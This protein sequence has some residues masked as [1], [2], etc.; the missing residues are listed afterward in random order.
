MRTT[1]RQRLEVLNRVLR[2]NLRNSMNVVRGHA[3]RL[4]DRIGEEDLRRSV[5]MILQ[6]SRELLRL[7]ERGSEV[8][9]VLS[10]ES[11]VGGHT[12]L[13]RVVD[14]VLDDVAS[15]YPDGTFV[16]DVPADVVLDGP[17][18]LLRITLRHLVENA[19]EHNDSTAPTVEVEAT[20]D[21]G[22]Y[23]LTISV[24]D[25]GPGIPESETRVIRRGTET[26]LEHASN[27]GLWVVKWAVTRLGGEVSFDDRDPTGTAVTLRL[28]GA[29]RPAVA[30]SV[31]TDD[32]ST[33]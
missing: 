21:A 15:R 27:L 2:H 16:S 20:Y 7:S 29:E 32:S 3:E 9:Q 28:P 31:P 23:P 5:E 6:S 1:R 30:G 18:D 22:A 10:L 8:E 24:L 17:G 26:D 19:I 33:P 13:E 4:R 12:P 14:G 25:N 11:S